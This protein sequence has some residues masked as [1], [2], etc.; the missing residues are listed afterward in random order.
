MPADGLVDFGAQAQGAGDGPGGVG[1]VGGGVPGFELRPDE[2]Q[3]AGAE[4]VAVGHGRFLV[5][6]LPGAGVDERSQLLGNGDQ[7]GGDGLAVQ[8]RRSEDARGNAKLGLGSQQCLHAG[9]LL[10]SRHR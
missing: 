6:T 1:G 7:G 4:A 10:A 2:H 5:G 9:Y 3:L 8:P